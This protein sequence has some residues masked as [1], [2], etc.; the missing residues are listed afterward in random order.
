[1]LTW[2]AEVTALQTLHANACARH[3]FWSRMDDLTD[4]IKATM[5]GS[6]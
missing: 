3:H 6:R 4:I 5:L 2:R 1:M